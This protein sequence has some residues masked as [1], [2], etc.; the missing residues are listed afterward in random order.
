MDL[1]ASWRAVTNAIMAQD[2]EAFRH[3]LAEDVV[4]VQAHGRRAVP[5]TLISG[6]EEAVE[7]TRALYEERPW[8][9]EI[10]SA[11]AVGNTLT[12]HYRNFFNGGQV[13]VGAAIIRY[14]EDGRLRELYASS[15]DEI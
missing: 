12:I 6:A 2:W 3:E 11:L 1:V 14:D 15:V 7:V 5:T 8:K 9:H 13:A 10:V 4:H